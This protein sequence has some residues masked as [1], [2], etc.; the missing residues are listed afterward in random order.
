MERI[1]QNLFYLRPA[2][3]S[4][5]NYYFQIMKTRLFHLVLLSGIATQLFSQLTIR[6]TSIPANTPQNDPIHIAGS[7]Q[8]W[9]PG[10]PNY[11]LSESNNGIYFITFTPPAGGIEYKFTRGNWDTV[12][13]NANGGF[14]PNRS[15]N[16]AG[17]LDTIE[18][19]ILS[20]EGS[21]GGQ[22][23]AAD[24][25]FLLDD[26]FF[27]PQLNRNRR[28]WIYL[29]PDYQTSGK[30]Y[31]V[32]YMHDGQNLFDYATSAFGEWEVDE[33]LNELFSQGDYGCIV[34]GIDNGGSARLDELS[35]WVNA[36]YNEGG[37]GDEYL[38]F[39]LETLKPFVDSHYRTLS[40]REYTATMG[41]SLGGLISHYALI[42][43]QDVVSKAGIFSPAYWFNSP[44]IFNHTDNTPKNF[45]LKAYLI[46]GQIEG[47]SSDPANKVNQ[48][49]NLM[50]SNGFTDDVEVEKI[51][52]PDGA[53]SEW[54]WAREFPAAYQW[55][56]A[57]VD[58][59]AAGEAAS[60]QIRL[61]PVPT[62]SLLHIDN[63]S[64]LTKPSYRMYSADGRL[65]KK[66]KISGSFI[67]VSRLPPG[68]YVLNLF[69]KNQQKFS[70]KFLIK[71]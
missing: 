69:S 3:L 66:G 51:I 32:M 34:V 70:G 39:M 17:G 67:D 25:V 43:H 12:E 19:Q 16:Y 2:M 10:D 48:M 37:Q 47:N 52:H 8:N 11:Q 14:L 62:D 56:F 45:N 27:M 61:R 57:G 53:H 59:T 5:P 44:E 9:N 20:W 49:H 65:V 1:S 7:F 68:L 36:S 26:D 63:V 24:N 31:P 4:G 23:S 40:G 21:T 22:G 28:I 60:K 71:R 58:F 42:E 46:V 55:L 41:S 54:Y 50:L 13:G 64:T 15:Y 6:V 30:H 18:H 33:S 35:P 29:P 38:D